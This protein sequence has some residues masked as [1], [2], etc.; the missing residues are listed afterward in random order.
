M[1]P[2]I[3]HPTFKI[4]IP[5]IDKEVRFRPFTV[6][7]EKILL[8]AQSTGE[9]KDVLEAIL[10]VINNCAVDDVDVSELT[11]F[12]IDYVF[13][14][15][16]GRSVNNIIKVTYRDPETDESIDIQVNIDE[17]DLKRFEGHEDVKNIPVDDTGVGLVMRYPRA[18][19]VNAIGSSTA[20]GAVFDIFKYC[21]DKVYDEESVY[22]LHDGSQ[23]PE[24]V[25]AFIESLPPAAVA[26]IEKFFE[27]MPRLEHI[28]KYTTK[29]GK[30]REVVLKTL[31]DFFI[32]A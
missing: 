17:V 15:L 2:K 24:E 4:R 7:E 16:R 8:I 6:K 11:S 14:K 26:K 18:D 23:S 32:L 9:M 25:D 19:I 27:T 3:N 20:E 29:D 5:S 28:V 31:S 22:S 21:I 12:D 10:Q 30:E 13:I 1:L